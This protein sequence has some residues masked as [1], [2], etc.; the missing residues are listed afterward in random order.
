MNQG[1]LQSEFTLCGVGIHT[2]TEGRIT[3]CPAEP[4][5]GRVF[6]VNGATIP[7]RA[8][9]VV[10][11]QRC[12]TL[13][14]NGERVSTVEHLLSALFACGVDNARIVME[15]REIPILDG[16][17]LPFV[18]VILAAGVCEQSVLAREF[19]L[20]S[21]LSF[22]DRDCVMRV[23]PSAEYTLEVT[24]TFPQW[25]EGRAL[26]AFRFSESVGDEYIAQ[27]ALARTFAFDYE[28]RW[29]LE[30]GLAKGGSLD[31]ALVITPPESFSTPLRIEAEW[32]RHKILD[33]I[34][35]LALLDCRPKM[36]VSAICPGHRNN[37][38]LAQHL[39]KQMSADNRGSVYG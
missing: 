31:N 6:V 29:L 30:Q 34:G 3:V 8:D 1:T 28:V 35:D 9:Y 20:E 26:R 14:H 7:A 2:G 37:V 36:S 13:G 11:T 10:D 12:T 27:V 22:T 18:E 21:E 38:N 32:C 17:A 19:T 24:T 39:L 25:E 23:I 4:N 15:G 16:S 5:A 33:L